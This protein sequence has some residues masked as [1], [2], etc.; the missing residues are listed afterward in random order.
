M[1]IGFQQVEREEEGIPIEC[2]GTNGLA[3]KMQ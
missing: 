3:D 1:G 2:N